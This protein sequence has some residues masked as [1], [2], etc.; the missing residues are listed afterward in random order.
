MISLAPYDSF[1]YFSLNEFLF[2][3]F[4]RS[5]SCTITDYQLRLERGCASF[6]WFAS[7]VDHVNQERMW[8]LSLIVLP[9]FRARDRSLSIISP[10]LTRVSISV[11]VS[12]KAYFLAT[13]QLG[14]GFRERIGHLPFPFLVMRTSAPREYKT[15]DMFSTLKRKSTR[16]QRISFANADTVAHSIT[17]LVGLSLSLYLSIEGQTT[18]ANLIADPETKQ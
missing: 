9:R 4:R 16:E 8:N 3:T 12:R 14:R 13:G 7:R 6:S 5:D 10:N 17:K 2:L 11:Y 15:V 18:M 1:P